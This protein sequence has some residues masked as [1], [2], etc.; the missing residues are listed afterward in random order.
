M[1]DLL[2]QVFLMSSFNFLT[3]SLKITFPLSFGRNGPKMEMFFFLGKKTKTKQE[4]KVA[5]DLHTIL[6]LND[7][8]NLNMVKADW[9]QPKC[10]M[11]FKLNKN[12]QDD[13]MLIWKRAGVAPHGQSGTLKVFPSK[14]RSL[15]RG[16]SWTRQPTRQHPWPP[17]CRYQ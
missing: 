6:F 3:A 14:D 9:E 5:N 8:L 11:F 10:R 16:L 2:V 13:I 7:K 4:K 15:F 17:P 1:A 12:T